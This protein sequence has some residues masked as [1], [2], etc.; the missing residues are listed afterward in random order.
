MICFVIL[1]GSCNCGKDQLDRIK[2][3]RPE[4][5]YFKSALAS[6]HFIIETSSIAEVDSVFGQ[7][8]DFYDLPLSAEGAKDGVYIGSSPYD[9]FD[10]RHEVRIKIEQGKVTELDYNE[11]KRDGN[12][13]Q[14][15]KAYCEEMSASGTS[16]AI[17]YPAMEEMFLSSQNIM[18]VD[19]VTGATYSLYRFRYA[20][21]VALM[22]ALI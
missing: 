15:D 11:L 22:Q 21:C 8:I 14:G 17:A 6:L 18:Q 2:A 5:K 7:L 1:A 9:A 13:K 10:Y 4:D 3:F 19:A 12:G 16:P 20:V